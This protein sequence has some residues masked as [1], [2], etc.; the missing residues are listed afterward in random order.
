MTRSRLLAA[1]VALLAVGAG[2]VGGAVLGLPTLSAATSTAA[3]TAAAS[4]TTTTVPGKGRPYWRFR[5]AD[6]AD[7]P[8]IAAAAKALNLTPQQLLDKLQDGKTTIA[9]V[10]QQQHVDVNTVINAMAAAD[11]DR[12][13]K[14]VNSPW[15][16]GPA[17]P[18]GGAITK[19]GDVGPFF[20]RKLIGQSVDT[21]ANALHISTAELKTDLQSGKSIADIAKSKGINVNSV[22]NTL[23]A[24]ASSKVDQ[25]VAAGKLTT[26][27]AN[28]IKSHLQ[29]AITNLVNN[30]LPRFPGGRFGFGG[31]PV[32]GPTP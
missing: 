8:L 18:N 21:V 31:R 4:P 11:K 13:S 3:H 7:S 2:V 25:A 32:P 16:S 28:T 6:D 27:Q 30:N 19:P 23:V 20:G 24:D 12:I 22:I 10:A 17:A 9:E 29:T 14:I 26:Q 1:G 5:R 15:P